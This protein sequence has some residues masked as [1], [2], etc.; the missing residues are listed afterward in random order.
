[1]KSR[2]WCQTRILAEPRWVPNSTRKI[3]EKIFTRVFGCVV[4]KNVVDEILW[5]VFGF[6]WIFMSVFGIQ[7][8]S[9][10]TFRWHFWTH[11]KIS[12]QSCFLTLALC[13]MPWNYSQLARN[14][15]IGITSEIY[16]YIY[17]RCDSNRVISRQLTVVPWHVT[18]WQSQETP[19]EWNFTASSK[20][21]PK[22]FSWYFLDSK[23]T[24]ENSWEFKYCSQNFADNVFEIYTSENVGKFFLSIFRVE[25]STKRGS[26]SI[27]VL[28]Q[29]LIFKCF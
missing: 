7:K 12:L 27:L 10:E 18:Q 22:S 14:H 2:K 13:N 5:T 24:H 9:G 17:L 4:F 21:W 1:M 15:P 26:V 11:H 23:N 28:Y 29:F 8:I 3:W 19:L 16:I 20:M 6:S 25:F